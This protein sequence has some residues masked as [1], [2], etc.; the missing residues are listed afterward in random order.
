MIA[1]LA[2]S[3]A[4]A[5]DTP[6]APPAAAPA[7][8]PAATESSAPETREKPAVAAPRS[9]A[10]KGAEGETAAPEEP[11]KK[12]ASQTPAEAP[13]AEAPSPAAAPKAKAEV[14]SSDNLAEAARDFFERLLRRDTEGAVAYCR[15]PFF[16]EGKAVNTTDEVR[17]R[18]ADAI[19]SRAVERLTLYGIE[20]LTPEQMEAKYGKPP[21][22]LGNWPTR[23]GMITVAN[24][25]GQAAVM[26]WKKSGNGWTAIAFHD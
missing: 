9:A 20:V 24:L 22:K 4:M 10:E 26:L 23:G 11:K 16:F 17:R 8:A 25:S 15:T 21:S 3:T 6:A 2:A 5:Q 19:N 13:P 1:A 14:R 12:R 7:P 18:W